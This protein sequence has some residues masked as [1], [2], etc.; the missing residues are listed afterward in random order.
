[1]WCM[2][3]LPTA[4]PL[5][6]DFFFNWFPYPLF[7][8]VTV[9]R[10]SPWQAHSE[11]Y[12]L[13]EL[14][15][16]N[17]LQDQD[18]LY[19]HT[20]SNVHD[21]SLICVSD[22]MHWCHQGQGLCEA[23][24]GL[25]VNCCD[26]RNLF[27]RKSAVQASTWG[28]AI[29]QKALKSASVQSSSPD[30]SG[31]NLISLLLIPLRNFHILCLIK[32]AASFFSSWHCHKINILSVYLQAA[33][34][35][36]AA[37]RSY[38]TEACSVAKRPLR[39][40]TVLSCNTVLCC[41]AT[42]PA[43]QDKCL[44]M[45][46]YSSRCLKA[47]YQLNRT[48]ATL[49]CRIS[50]AHLQWDYDVLGIS[51]CNAQAIRSEDLQKVYLGFGKKV[52]LIQQV[53]N[54]GWHMEVNSRGRDVIHSDSFDGFNRVGTI[55]TQVS[56]ATLSAHPIFGAG[57]PAVTNAEGEVR[58]L[59]TEDVSLPAIHELHCPSKRY[60]VSSLHWSGPLIAS[61]I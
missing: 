10:H 30:M 52:T 16:Q 41:L 22:T 57:Q 37:A 21:M 6:S 28:L 14:E 1:M 61:L 12:L 49:I 54:Y 58:Q 43:L 47:L 50:P 36:S 18:M 11:E 53:L 5:H 31:E 7:I 38:L 17:F 44:Q 45:L 56:H 27:E 20:D 4:V 40:Q 33:M 3:S 29:C 8:Y 51:W 35:M 46:S 13:S 25:N 32:C 42:E 48:A 55:C 59:P 2:K 60:P 26:H 9:D 23:T 24:D 39:T 15:L 19:R 34:N